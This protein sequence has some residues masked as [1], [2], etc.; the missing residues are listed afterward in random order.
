MIAQK[1][2]SSQAIDWQRLAQNLAKNGDLPGTTEIVRTVS[3]I[4][5]EDRI[6]APQ[7]ASLILRDYGLTKRVIRL[8]NSCFYNPQGVEIA[9]VSKAIIFLG[10]EVVKKIALATGFLEEILQKVPEERRR[11][12]LAL[13]SRS[14]FSAFLG[15]KLASHL[16]KDKEEFFIHLLFHRLMRVLLAIHF[17]QEYQ[18][19]CR[20]EEEN[21]IEAKEGLY[22]LGEF[23]GKSWSFPRSL[24]ETFEGSPKTE[25]E[26]H[27][28]SLVAKID[29]ATGVIISENNRAPLKALLKKLKLE[30]RLADELV[31]FAYR[32]ATELYRP[33]GKYFVF[34]SEKGK[35]EEPS[36][37]KVTPRDEFFQK[38]LAEIT[39][40]LASPENKS[41]EVLFMVLE[42]IC[43]AFSCESVLFAIYQP[44]RGLEV[45]LVV[46]GKNGAFKQ[47]ILPVGNIL[48]EIFEKKT[49]WAGKKSAIPEFQKVP[50]PQETDIL[51]SPLL[52][53]GKPLGMIMAFRKEPFSTAEAQKVNILK[54]LAVT[55]IAQ[56]RAQRGEF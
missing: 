40:L 41:Q 53:F 14:F 56:A 51:F 23:L 3:K 7:L 6:S 46:G 4:N 10:F 12:I 49:E 34:C 5:P 32:G 35:D 37:R 1:P 33:F 8:A 27:P 2:L 24:V 50:F 39:A 25:D 17:P 38:A 19:L 52:V 9:T 21:P 29:A 54:N 55:S 13:L 48:L 42:T 47:K 44:Q 26:R 28:A 43:R 45:R 11:Q 20:L 36:S 31:K 22:F 15:G 16:Q 18:H 30:E